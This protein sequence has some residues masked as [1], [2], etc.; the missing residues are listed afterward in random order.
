MKLKIRHQNNQFEVTV[1]GDTV[2]DV[3]KAIENHPPERQKLIHKGKI[4]KDEKTLQEY[5]IHEND[6]LFLVVSKGNASAAAAAPAQ[7]TGRATGAGGIAA[8]APS[9][10]LSPRTGPGLVGNNPSPPDFQM[11]LP[12]TSG[13]EDPFSNPMLQ[14]LLNNP[15]LMASILESQMQNNPQLRQLMESNPEIR[16]AL[17]D[18]QQIQQMMNMMRNPELRNQMMRQQDLAMMNLENMPGGFNALS[19][20][21]NDI[22]APLQ[23]S[24]EGATNGGSGS[25]GTSNPA[26][27]SAGASG[28]AMPN[29]WGAPPSNSTNPSFQFNFDAVPG[30][31]PAQSNNTS[32]S[33]NPA[34]FPG[35]P[36]GFQF[37]TPSNG[38]LSGMG[39]PPQLSDEQM[40]AMLSMM[41][42]PGMRQMM[43]TFLTDSALLQMVPEHMRSMLEQNPQMMQTMRQSMTDPN[44]LRMAM[45][46]RQQMGGSS[47]GFGADASSGLDFSSLLGS[48][49]S[50][51]FDFASMMGQLQ[52]S[53]APPPAVNIN[54]ADRYRTQLRSLFDMGFDDEQR[55]LRVLQQVNGNLNR[56]IDILLSGSDLNNNNN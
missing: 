29:P 31:T 47:P 1:D 39:I 35:F 21:Y 43:D 22:Q 53:Q 33:S 55:C 25:T 32:N 52:Q 15:Q 42:Q 18:P 8:P 16:N 56:A 14:G 10:T 45:R 4:L 6:T 7:A 13:N 37:A 49:S 50:P 17:Q 36:G 27:S 3:K 46:M 48:S 2:L 38:D 11:N 23:D 5:N 51:N 41:E 24:M 54:P 40:E 30:A 44:M 19:S 34:S 20:M 28:T 26:N 9:P 12:G